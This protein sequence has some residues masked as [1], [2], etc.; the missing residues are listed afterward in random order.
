MH[1]GEQGLLKSLQWKQ[2]VDMLKIFNDWFDLFNS[3]YKYGYNNTSHA[4]GINLEEQNAILDNMNDFIQAMR[5][6]KRQTLLQFQKG[7]LLSKSLRD[8]FVHIQKQY[9]GT[10]PVQ[11][12]LTNRLNQD[13]LENVFLFK[14]DGW[15]I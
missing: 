12:L 4:Y 3:K 9:S 10:R 13:L 5:V 1:Y 15:R 7:I 2:T 6:G 11:Y 14:N 8:L